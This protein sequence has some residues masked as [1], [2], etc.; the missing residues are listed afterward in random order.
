M[1]VL[2]TGGAGYIG[3]MIAWSLLD[4]GYQPIVLDS[5]ITGK[6]EFVENI[7]GL[8]F[9]E[10]DIGNK[11]LVRDILDDHPDLRTV[12]HC[13]ALVVVPESTAE[14][15]RYYREN[16]SKS[17]DFFE[18]LANRGGMTVVFSSSAS[19]YGMVPDFKVTE[20]APLAPSSP[21]A[22]TKYMMEMVLSDFC[23][24]YDLRGLALR[25]F[26]PIGADPQLRTGGHLRNPSHVLAKIVNAALGIEAEFQITGTNWPTRDGS[27][28]RDYIHV[29]DLARAH[30]QAAEK[31]ANPKFFETSQN[32]ANAG[33][34]PSSG[35]RYQVINLGTGQGVTVQEL[36][37]AFRSVW[38]K[39]FEAKTAPARPGD[40]AGAFADTGKA[41]RLLGWECRYT[42]AE[43]IKSELDWREARKSKLGY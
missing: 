21:Y 15:A 3:N 8:I 30:V 24:A 16:V 4:A 37:D 29:A 35:L 23:A 14:P 33:T 6:R 42:S 25:Y 20:D 17:V 12:I 11:S 36:V 10:G 9:Y 39:P 38:K 43:A 13:A 31:V 22:R 5:L 32:S 27:G 1:K 41:G 7:P 40:V 18:V 2:V 19:I 28:I 26:N 34:L